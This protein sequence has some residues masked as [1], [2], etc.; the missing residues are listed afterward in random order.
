MKI[1]R[2][3]EASL[4]KT[5]N[6]T[7]ERHQQRIKILPVYRI[8]RLAYLLSVVHAQRIAPKVDFIGDIDVYSKRCNALRIYLST[9]T[10]SCIIYGAACSLACSVDCLGYAYLPMPRRNQYMSS[11]GGGMPISAPPPPPGPPAAPEAILSFPM[12]IRAWCLTLALLTEEVCSDS[13]R[14]GSGCQS[15]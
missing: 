7:R 2:F 5:S 12:N 3:R 10:L 8:C 6:G 15:R 11:I 13:R 1:T 4:S 14:S 9:F